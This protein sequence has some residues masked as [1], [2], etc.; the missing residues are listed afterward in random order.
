MTNS[1]HTRIGVGLVGAST[2]RG[3]GGI[4]HVPALQALDA[5]QIR[6][7]STT[8]MESANAT[9]RRLGADLAFDTHEA[10]VV[11]P[12]VDLVVV[13]V[14]VPDHKQIVSDA[15]AAGK[16]VYC[17]WPLARN[18]SE[19]E[20]L[21]GFA[22]ER[23]LRTVV[24]LQGG[25]HPPVL[26]L[27]DLIAQGAIGKPLSTSIRAHLADDMWVGRYDPPVEYMAHAKNGATLLSIML[28][29]GLEPLARVLGTF[30]SLSAVVANQRGDG[31]RL[32][33]GASLPKDAPDEIVVAGVLEGGIVTSLHYS[34]GQSAGPA[35]VWEIQGT[36]GSVRVES[37]SGYIHFTD[38]TI[39][40]CRGSE[41]V[42]VL[43]VPPAYAAPDLQ[44]DAPAA[45]V[46]RL[47]AQFAADLRNGTADA[48]DFAVALDR[49]RA[50]EAITR[51]AETGH[52]QHLSRPTE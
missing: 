43:E 16:M 38:F 12:E 36:E 41:P 25:L 22:R 21:E 35:M 47:Y 20:A 11:R 42:Q 9:A 27:R 26:F 48:P 4:A 44:L 28:G 30:E 46:A 2:D 51:A 1:A 10:L 6:A 5:F 40:L 34:A 17:E 32:S 7:V 8:R 24:G 23:R 19:A 37:A 49:H 14:K 18:L 45:G 39:T 52:R 50:L 15:L 31:V 3:W 29:H 13:A 33:D